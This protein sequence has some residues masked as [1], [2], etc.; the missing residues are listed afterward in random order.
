MYLV[1]FKDSG[2]N[3]IPN[4]QGSSML[5]TFCEEPLQTPSTINS[6]FL[7][8]A[9]NSTF[10]KE[11]IYI[12]LQPLT[13]FNNSSTITSVMEASDTWIHYYQPQVNVQIY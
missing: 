3:I 12:D 6:A 7:S 11:N 8:S 5:G 4:N 2:Y 13:L 1:W 9:V 10:Y